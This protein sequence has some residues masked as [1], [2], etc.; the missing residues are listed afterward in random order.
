MDS[1]VGQGLRDADGAGGD[2]VGGM[3]EVLSRS[4]D[5]PPIFALRIASDDP[6]AELGA[7]L[8]DRGEVER[9]VLHLTGGADLLSDE[10]DRLSQVR[11][12]RIRVIAEGMD[13][14]VLT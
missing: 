11:G 10:V 12:V 7:W 9:V 5:D 2:G 1:V 3:I 14:P 6:Y 13:E 4:D 8:E